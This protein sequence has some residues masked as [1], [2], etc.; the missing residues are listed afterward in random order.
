MLLESD[1]FK[2]DGTFDIRPNNS[3]RQIYSWHTVLP[4]GRIVPA[5]IGFL[6]M[7]T[8]DIYERAHREISAKINEYFDQ[9]WNPR[10]IMTDNEQ[11][12]MAASKVFGK[13]CSLT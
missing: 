2:S 7:A 13:R 3:W 5:V 4:E 11:A 1:G 10:L 6:A 9:A 12:M 8:T